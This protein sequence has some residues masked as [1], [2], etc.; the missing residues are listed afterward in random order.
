MNWWMSAL[1]C[2]VLLFVISRGG[3]PVLLAV[4][5]IFLPVVLFLVLVKYVTQLLFSD[6]KSSKKIPESQVG[7]DPDVIRI[8]SSCGREELSCFKCKLGFKPGE[9]N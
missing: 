2:G 3:L 4:A 6:K 5:K 1:L 7:E 9:K 8:C